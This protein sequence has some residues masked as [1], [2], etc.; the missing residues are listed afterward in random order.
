MNKLFLAAL[1]L[2]LSAL[3]YL[4]Y[5]QYGDDDYGS[6]PAIADSA[7]HNNQMNECVKLALE[8]HPGAIL[9]TEV[10]MEEG[11]L[12]TDVDIQ[13]DDGKK[14]EVECVLASKE[15]IEDKLEN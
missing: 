5:K 10:E 4:G 8:K 9:E 12:I 11:Q 2:S 1:I 14:W 15:L 7:N 6:R 3:G 13:G